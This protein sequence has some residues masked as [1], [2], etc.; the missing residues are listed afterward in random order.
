M[1]L[2]NLLLAI[3]GVGSVAYGADPNKNPVQPDPRLNATYS[4]VR[5][6]VKKHY[7]KAA[8]H[9]HGAKIHFESDTRLF[10]IHKQLKTG[11]W[12]DPWTERGPNSGGILG[13]IQLKEGKYSGAAEL[14]QTFDQHY[15]NIIVMAPY[16]KKMD[17]Y[18]H[19]HL[20]VPQQGKND[21][22]IKAFTKAVSHFGNDVQQLKD[23]QKS[24]GK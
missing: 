17:C 13:V 20:Y 1:K 18:L 24:N 14:P 6:L 4:E 5:A 19:V 11:E 2:K 3:I 10:M 21:A 12:Q 23:E 7:P 8:S 16:S 9:L 15:Y 22:F